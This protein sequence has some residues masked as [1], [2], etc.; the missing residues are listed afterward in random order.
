VALVGPNEAGKSSLLRALR[1][2]LNKG[3]LTKPDRT[4]NESDEAK[5]VAN[6]LLDSE[7]RAATSH[8]GGAEVQ[9]LRLTVTESNG[10]TFR[11]HP[12]PERDL[13]ER[14]ALGVRL[15]EALD[16]ELG[17]LASRWELV[18]TADDDASNLQTLR[19]L[20]ERLRSSDESID[21]SVVNAVQEFGASISSL[22]IRI[23]EEDVSDDEDVEHDGP[24]ASVTLYDLGLAMESFEQLDS[25]HVRCGRAL[26]ERAP[27]AVEFGVPERDL[28]STYELDDE[29]IENPPIA[30]ANL[31]A[32]AELDLARL[33]QAMAD[34]DIGER[35]TLID[36]A[37]DRLRSAFSDA[38]TQSDVVPRVDVDGRTLS[39]VVSSE[40][41][42]TF[43]R[44]AERSDGLRW[45]VAMGSCS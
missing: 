31:C 34:D 28:R 22:D 42:T 18:M 14:N 39:L 21:T 7:D 3:A 41:G 26:L 17:T 12:R 35:L 15:K 20:A 33:A 13:S 6:F 38:W 1:I 44:V 37:N 24:S 36:S 43:T 29:V 16:G 30:L 23:E 19:H 9:G 5:I 27:R 25:P 45:F 40:D 10:R 11:L 4:R 2:I 32:L 8:L